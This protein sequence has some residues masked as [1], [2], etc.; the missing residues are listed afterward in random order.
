MCL[1]AIKI[2]SCGPV[3]IFAGL[4]EKNRRVGRLSLKNRTFEGKAALAGKW[5]TGGLEVGLSVI[6]HEP[7]IKSPYN[8]LARAFKW[9]CSVIFSRGMDTV[10]GWAE[11]IIR[12]CGELYHGEICNIHEMFAVAIALI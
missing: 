3:L 9:S 5:E 7:K 4:R 12:V 6:T 1:T 2:N 10:V 11:W 8:E